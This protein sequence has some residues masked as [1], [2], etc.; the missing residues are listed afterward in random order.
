MRKRLPQWDHSMTDTTQCL[1]RKTFLQACIMI[2]LF[3]EFKFFYIDTRMLYTYACLCDC[4]TSDRSGRPAVTFISWRY[5]YTTR[6]DQS[7]FVFKRDRFFIWSMIIIYNKRNFEIAILT[8]H[9][10]INNNWPISKRIESLEF[11]VFLKRW[12]LVSTCV[13][14]QAAIQIVC[15]IFVNRLNFLSKFRMWS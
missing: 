14:K 13:K 9:V 2:R 6:I 3:F 12:W 1:N 10:Q 8:W 5:F 7:N 15:A 11:G 4:L